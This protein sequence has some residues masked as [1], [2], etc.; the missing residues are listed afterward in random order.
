VRRIRLAMKQGVI[1]EL[2]K[3]L[4]SV[5]EA[6]MPML[7][8]KGI[9]AA[10]AEYQRLAKHERERWN[11]AEGE[12]NTLGYALLQHG[13]AASARRIFELNAQ[14]FPDSLNPQ[15]SRA[16]ACLALDDRV[17]VRDAFHRVLELATKIHGPRPDSV[18]QLVDRAKAELAK[19]E[20]TRKAEP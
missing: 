16:D 18:T 14:H 19:L 3:S 20:G 8:A 11:F 9:D 13:Q 7:Q 2:A 1:L 10:V 5:A 12:L 17:C 15:D 4:P 6:L